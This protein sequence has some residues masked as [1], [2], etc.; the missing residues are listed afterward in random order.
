MRFPAIREALTPEEYTRARAWTYSQHCIPHLTLEIAIPCAPILAALKKTSAEPVD[1][2]IQ[3]LGK[4][5]CDEQFRNFRSILDGKD[6]VLRGAIDIAV[7]SPELQSEGR[8]ILSEIDRLSFAD[9][10]QK[11]RALAKQFSISPTLCASANTA[12]MS[13]I[14][15]GGTGMGSGEERI[16]PGE[17]AVLTVYDAQPIALQQ[18]GRSLEILPAW[19]VTLSVDR[20][21]IERN[22][23]V[24]FLQ[25]F[26]KHLSHTASTIKTGR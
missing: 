21:L 4:L 15:Y 3:A 11:R 8:L 12:L 26:Q 2:F 6:R 5:L 13:L 9:L 22:S 25:S 18:S 19:K 7:C 16:W 1:F 10:V 14:Y 23:A 24:N 17:S 20:R